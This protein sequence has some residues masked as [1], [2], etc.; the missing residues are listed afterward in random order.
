[1]ITLQQI[2]PAPEQRGDHGEDPHQDAGAGVGVPPARHFQQQRHPAGPK[3][4]PWRGVAE[5]ACVAPVELGDHV[6]DERERGHVFE[7]PVHDGLREL[8]VSGREG[9]DPVPLRR[10]CIERPQRRQ[11]QIRGE[12][13]HHQPQRGQFEPDTRVHGP[14]TGGRAA[15]EQ[16][17]ANREDGAGAD[18]VEVAQGT[19]G[20]RHEHPAKGQGDQPSAI[21]PAFRGEVR[22]VDGA[23]NRACERRYRQHE[24][25]A[26]PTFAA[27][28]DEPAERDELVHQPHQRQLEGQRLYGGVVFHPL[29]QLG[30]QPGAEGGAGRVGGQVQQRRVAGGGEELHRLDGGAER[31][32]QDHHAR[33]AGGRAAGP[34]K[35]ID[36]AEGY[37]HQHV[38]DE[39]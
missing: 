3:H 2:Q 6:P 14:V 15:A 38:H 18:Q 31:G 11:R 27:H 28:P 30:E 4:H 34:G 5:A 13:R 8:H 23:Q 24:G 39:V 32:A 20:H 1:M 17:D 21:V 36:E 22:R 26:G 19:R 33:P 7:Q 10:H 16:G 29:G 25:A 35:L 37:E 9:H 12:Q